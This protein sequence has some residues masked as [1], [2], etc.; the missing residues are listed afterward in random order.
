[1]KSLMFDRREA[2]F[3]HA[4]TK[5]VL[6]PTLTPSYPSRRS[7]FEFSLCRMPGVGNA[8]VEEVLTLP[9]VFPFRDARRRGRGKCQLR[10]GV[11]FESNAASRGMKN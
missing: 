4:A 7:F 10:Q 11:F 9:G 3:S 6:A 5:I 8:P 2:R 1:M